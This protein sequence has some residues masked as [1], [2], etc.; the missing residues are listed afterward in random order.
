M[1]TRPRSLGE[2]Q[3]DD[4]AHALNAVTGIAC[5]SIATTDGE[6]QL[7]TLSTDLYRVDFDFASK[8]IGHHEGAFSTTRADH[9]MVDNLRSE[10]A[11]SVQTR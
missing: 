6:I 9:S 10:F 3:P 5:P 4:R 7:L 2:R 11:N 1:P 8:A